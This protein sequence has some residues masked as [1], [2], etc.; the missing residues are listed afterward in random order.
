MKF[1][2]RVLAA[3]KVVGAAPILRP[4]TPS[5][6]AYRA[7]VSDQFVDFLTNQL[8]FKSEV[9]L[10]VRLVVDDCP[11]LIS[12]ERT[13]LKEL[14]E[15]LIKIVDLAICIIYTTEFTCL[16]CFSEL[17]LTSFKR[18]TCIGYSYFMNL[19]FQI[20]QGSLN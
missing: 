7:F 9:P 11:F 18:T 10:L 13:V 4:I 2:M 17:K 3:I 15:K 6:D 14:S 16:K 8:C 1:G 19:D 5:I 20:N 12:R